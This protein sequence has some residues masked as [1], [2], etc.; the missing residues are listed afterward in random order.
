MSSPVYLGRKSVYDD[1]I[2]GC[3]LALYRPFT[4]DDTIFWDT[5]LGDESAGVKVM[6]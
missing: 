2:K 4:R 3:C 5:V 1:A 6:L